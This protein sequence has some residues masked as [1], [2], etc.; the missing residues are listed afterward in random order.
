MKDI[1]TFFKKKKSESK[2]ISVLTCY[3][4]S[5]ARIF[6]D[7]ELDCILVGDSLG[8][9]FQGQEST[10]PV[11]LEEMIYHAKA[12]K[13]GASAIPIICDLPFLSYHVSKEEGI[14]A[15]G[16]VMQETGSAAV[17]IEGASPYILDLVSHLVEIGIPVVGHLGLT[18]Q[19]ARVLGGHRLQGKKPEEALKILE[20]AKNLEKAGVFSIVLEMIP[21]SLGKEIT[22]TIQVPTIGIG[23]GRFTDGQVL[24]INDLL[25]MNPD[26]NPRFLK[27]YRDLYSIIRGAVEEYDREVKSSE[28]PGEK[29]VF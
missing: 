19:S 5:T 29:N 10:M 3:D 24:V 15:C 18:P 13:R 25:G 4:Y 27:K 16:R 11:S 20:G 1:I 17:K 23:A 12:V 28:F 8:M 9:V 26:F 22:E 6:S 2:K 14:R 7:T 21:E